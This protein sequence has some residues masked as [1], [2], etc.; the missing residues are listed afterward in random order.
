MSKID[1]LTHLFT[2]FPGI[3]SRQA[4]RFVYFLLNTD[5]N[6]LRKFTDSLSSLDEDIDRCNSCYRLFERTG[7]KKP[8]GKDNTICHICS[9]VHNEQSVL[10][11]VE[12]DVDFLN[13][14]KSGFYNGQYFI[15]GGL[16]S[17]TKKRV[18]PIR[19]KELTENICK[20]AKECGLQ[21][22]ILALS[23]NP[24]GDATTLYLTETLQPY[25][26]K[27]GLKISTLGRGLSTGTELEYS[28][29][30]TIKNAL[31]NRR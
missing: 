15:L 28:D 19:L 21:E 7:P 3:G 5:K 1:H 31:K 30:E 23:A 6:F 9:D 12:K 4:Q 17:L 29:E 24:E 25:L 27:Y 22:V 2:K 10:L 8:E 13:I 16:V 18:N 26:E 14:R 11:I 20:K